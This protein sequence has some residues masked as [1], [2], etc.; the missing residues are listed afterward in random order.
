[1]FKIGSHVIRMPALTFHE[2]S[3]G[4]DVSVT[5]LLLLSHF[6]R[7]LS[8]PA[9][10]QI[11][12]RVHGQGLMD[13]RHNPKFVAGILPNPCAIPQVQIRQMRG[14]L[15]QNPTDLLMNRH[16]IAR[17]SSHDENWELTKLVT[18]NELFESFLLGDSFACIWVARNGASLNMWTSFEWSERGPGDNGLI[19]GCGSETDE[20]E[21]LSQIVDFNLWWGQVDVRSWREAFLA[22]ELEF[23]M[24]TREQP[25][26]TSASF[27]Y[28]GLCMK[29]SQV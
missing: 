26:D 16:D 15:R 28:D 22:L 6:S 19:S 23:T 24:D 8:F 27:N 5:P 1:M 17:H 3:K 9:F 18:Q 11:V 4:L 7:G 21:S 20:K 13:P 29:S 25:H 14:F 10:I 2:F 12:L